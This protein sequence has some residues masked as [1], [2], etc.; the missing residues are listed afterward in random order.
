MSQYS[1]KKQ[2]IVSIIKHNNENNKIK[3]KRAINRNKNGD[4]QH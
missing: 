4:K 3:R 2:I 1:Q